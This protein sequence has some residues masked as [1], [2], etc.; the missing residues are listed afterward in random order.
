VAIKNFKQLVG[1]KFH[2]TEMDIEDF[3]KLIKDFMADTSPDDEVKSIEVND[4][5][6]VNIKFESG[7]EEEIEVDWNELT[8]K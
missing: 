7:K 8:L 2:S 3:K 4:E 5:G 6:I 1:E